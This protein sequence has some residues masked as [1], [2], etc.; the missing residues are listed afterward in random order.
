MYDVYLFL[1]VA[2]LGEHEFDLPLIALF[3][4]LGHIFLED[5]DLS[6]KF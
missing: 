6:L 4:E 2:H 3:F 5:V 1:Q